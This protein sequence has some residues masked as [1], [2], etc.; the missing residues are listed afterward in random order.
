LFEWI[1][2]QIFGSQLRMLQTMNAKVL[3]LDVARQFYEQGPLTRPDFY[4]T[5]SFEQWLAFLRAAGFIL[6]SGNNVQ[7][8]IRGRE[9][10]KYLTHCGYDINQKGG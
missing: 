2:W 6:E 9:F 3:T 7:I 4:K 1:W 8:T 10:L 5:Y